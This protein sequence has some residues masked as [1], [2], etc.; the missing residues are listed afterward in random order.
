[1][2]RTEVIELLGRIIGSYGIVF[3]VMDKKIIEEGARKKKDKE[4]IK[5]LKK[6]DEMREKYYK[7]IKG[8]IRIEGK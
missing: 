3:E 7:K 2:K 6:Y 1:M 4:T 5:M 8:G